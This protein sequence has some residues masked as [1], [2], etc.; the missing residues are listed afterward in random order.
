MFSIKGEG[1]EIKIA[2]YY[3]D[4]KPLDFSKVKS[5]GTSEDEEQVLPDE[6]E[7]D[8]RKIFEALFA[9]GYD[10]VMSNI[11]SSREIKDK[12]NQRSVN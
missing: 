6:M 8:G 5:D 9:D 12:K 1:E 7:R 3:Y 11:I 2:N 4:N 10:D